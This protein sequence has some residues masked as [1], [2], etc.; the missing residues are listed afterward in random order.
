MHLNTHI[1]VPHM[2]RDAHAHGYIFN[3]S[4]QHRR[5]PFLFF[6]RCPVQLVINMVERHFPKKL[7]LPSRWSPQGAGPTQALFFSLSGIWSC[8]DLHPAPGMD[9]AEVD[10][11]ETIADV[12][13]KCSPLCAPHSEVPALSGMSDS[14]SDGARAMNDA[15][16]S[17]KQEYPVHA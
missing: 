12:G 4:E 1:P 2:Y 17:Y 9:E 7:F 8:P 13:I 10:G 14:S 15:C 3:K 11:A 5:R 16:S 6:L